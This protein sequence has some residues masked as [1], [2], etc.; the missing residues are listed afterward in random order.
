MDEFYY[1]VSFREK[2]SNSH[3]NRVDYWWLWLVFFLK[4][5][6]FIT[7]DHQVSIHLWL[8]HFVKNNQF[9]MKGKEKLFK[10]T[11]DYTVFFFIIIIA[12]VKDVKL[13]SA[14]FDLHQCPC[15]DVFQYLLKLTWVS[16]ICVYPSSYSDHGIKWLW[17][18]KWSKNCSL[19]DSWK[20][21]D[22]YQIVYKSISRKNVLSSKYYLTYLG[23]CDCIDAT[24]TK[25]MYVEEVTTQHYNRLT[26][27]PAAPTYR[28]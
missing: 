5:V 3:R 20:L 16:F 25:I 7:I 26:L 15:Y 27:I 22:I 18:K 1:I 2:G 23:A 4:N 14:E 11:Y 12:Y 6:S 10:C 8:T 17:I 28:V 24:F 13:I 21:Y 19:T 9:S